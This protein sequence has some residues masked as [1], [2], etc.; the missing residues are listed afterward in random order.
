MEI[1]DYNTSGAM[2]MYMISLEYTNPLRE[3]LKK[4]FTRRVNVKTY[5]EYLL[6]C[7]LEFL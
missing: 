7:Y 1:W 2:K 5:I 3:L 6:P 4:H